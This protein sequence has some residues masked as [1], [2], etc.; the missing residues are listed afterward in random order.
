MR[1]LMN[2]QNAHLVSTVQRMLQNAAHVEPE[3]GVEK[4]PKN[5]D[6]LNLERSL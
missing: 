2:A 6:F 3:S 5:A 1:K 4:E